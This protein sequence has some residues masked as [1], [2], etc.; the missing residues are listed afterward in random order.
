MKMKKILFLS[1]ILFSIQSFAQIHNINPDPNGE[2]W[3][4]GGL[5]IPDKEKLAQ[6]PTIILSQDDL[7]RSSLTLPAQ[8]DN[9]TQAYFRPI[10]NQSNGSCAQSSGV[11][12]NFTYEINRERGTS[13]AQVQNQYPSHY[14]YDFLNGG[15]GDNGS[16]YTDGWDIIIA[17][18]CPNIPA[19]GG[20]LDTGGAARWMSG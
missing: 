4:V 2:P 9:T 12:Y 10:F 1:L 5:K 6:I 15:S 11:A 7:N 18:G 8:L 16:F 14:T 3:M 13:A 20:A 19:Y 17:N